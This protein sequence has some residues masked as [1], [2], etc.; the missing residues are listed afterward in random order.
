M[1]R[2]SIRSLTSLVDSGGETDTAI[3]GISVNPVNDAPVAA[4]DAYEV[5]EGELLQ[6]DGIGRIT[7]E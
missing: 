1:K 5:Y 4:N 7:C 6:N 3:V 2:H